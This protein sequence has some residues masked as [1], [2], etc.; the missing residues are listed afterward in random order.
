M[1]SIIIVARPC[2]IEAEAPDGATNRRA[3]G[4]V[5]KRP[6][7]A[8]S[9]ATWNI[10]STVRRWMSPSTG[11]PSSIDSAGSLLAAPMLKT[12]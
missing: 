7:P 4:E 8:P 12:R 2:I 11:T 9:A 10:R 1:S 5:W 6:R 3:M